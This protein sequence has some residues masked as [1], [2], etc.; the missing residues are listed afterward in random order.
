MPETAIIPISRE[1]IQSH[2][3]APPPTSSLYMSRSK[4]VRPDGVEQNVVAGVHL[5][6]K[7]GDPNNLFESFHTP[8]SQKLDASTPPGPRKALL[9]ACDT[10]EIS[11]M[12]SLPEWEVAIF[13]R[14]LIFRDQGS[15]NTTPLDWALQK[16]ADF[17]PIN[18]KGGACGADGH[19][20]GAISV[21]IASMDAPSH[22]SMQRF[23]CRGGRGQD[24]GHG[25]DGADGKNMSPISA[26]FRRTD[27]GRYNQ[28]T[29]SFA[30][31]CVFAKYHWHWIIPTERGER[32]V[33]D[34]PTNGE[35]ALEP[36]APGSA[37]NGGA[38]FSNLA[39]LQALVDN[40]TGAAGAVAPS[41]RGGSAGTPTTST[42]YDLTIRFNLA[43]E[44]AGGDSDVT[45]TRTTTE[46]KGY[47]AKPAVHEKGET[48]EKRTISAANAWVHPF[49]LEAVLRYARDAFL[50]GVRGPVSELLAPYEKALALPLPTGKDAGLPWV[51]GEAARWTSAQAEIAGILHRLRNN[52]DYFGNPAGYMPFLSLQATLRLYDLE[53]KDAIRTLL[54]AAWVQDVANREESAA[55]AFGSAIEELNKD[56]ERI[57][58]QLVR[59]EAKMVSLDQ[60][61]TSLEN[62]LKE[63]GNDLGKLRTELFNEAA[64]NEQQKALIK[65]GVKMAAAICQVIPVGQPVLGTIGDLVNIA[66]DIDVEGVPDTVTKMGGTIT[67]AREA[68]NKS[69][70]AKDEAAKKEKAAAD[71]PAAKKK[72]G[73]WEIAGNGFGPALS[74]AGEAIGALQVSDEQI[75]T[76][77]AKLTAANPKWKALTDQIRKL[78]K[79]KASLFTQLSAVLQAMGDGY[80]QLADNAAS[81]VTMHQERSESLAKLSVEANQVIAKMGQTARLSLQ[82]SLYLFVKAY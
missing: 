46:G 11:G 45:E 21:F 17:D 65:A 35:H 2:G 15:I 48:K 77:L 43:G 54:L 1:T 27:T 19:H 49:Q 57:A 78:N 70:K 4:K 26:I 10:L 14:K 32:G 67:K 64:H 42:H 81:V 66:S 55:N 73:A 47:T 62:R 69:K 58:D 22:E 53:T 33:N 5:V 40:T 68:A 16:A 60:Q 31:P 79:D 59:S 34:W 52:L 82:R 76:E 75:E 12:L 3:E 30:N 7:A 51:E 13:T 50:A 18:R 28:F 20:A 56:T 24:A 29:A 80:A 23:V 8:R 39:Q 63:M 44:T 37:G 6:F 74:I 41:V 72:A 9:I 25:K 36:G 71:A 38:W 61:M